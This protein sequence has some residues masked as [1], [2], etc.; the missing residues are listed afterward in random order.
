MSLNSILASAP[1]TSTNY[2]LKAT[3]TTIGNSLIWDNGT[4]VG[5]GNQGTTYKL[6]V[7]G[8]GYFSGILTTGS[9]VGVGVTPS[10]GWVNGYA[11]EVG[12]VGSAVWGRYVNEF[13]LTN[14]YYY[15]A[16]TTSR[17]YAS[18]AP[19]SDYEQYNGIHTWSTAP[20]GT[21]N[22]AVTLT[23]RMTIT[24]AG[25]VGIGT[26]SPVTTNLV[27][28]L[29]IVKSY[30]G[31]TPTS[32]TAQAYYGTQSS[33]YLFGRN[34][35]VS[36]ISN[37]IEEGKIAFGNASTPIYASITT[38]SG[39][40]SVGGDM[41]FKVGSDTERMRITSGGNVGINNTTPSTY[42]DVSNNGTNNN[43]YITTRNT[44]ING[45]RS[46]AIFT[47]S[48]AGGLSWYLVST[49]NGDGD[50]GGGK[51]AI[52]TNNAVGVYLNGSTATTWTGQSD[53]R[54]KDIDSEIENAID[55]VNKL[56]GVRFTWKSDETKKMQVGLI[57]QEVKEVL[58]EAVDFEEG[59]EDYK[60][61]VQYT[62]IIPLLVNAIKE[63][64]AK[65]ETLEAII[66]KK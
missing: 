40:S 37:N 24:N 13:H 22:T 63:L 49:N 3:G 28:A 61:G 53:I 5:I 48:A 54:L 32:T 15:S 39:T 8:T 19:A 4:N 9:N 38:G 21:I 65:V 51:F 56:R 42:L 17:L 16:S 2:I 60:M 10:N 25:N 45:Y 43:A 50:W 36:I 58:P 33:L 29:T 41:Y 47:N 55:K 57:A 11:L 64:S 18:T 12:F 44:G 6:E 14:N 66:N 59:N 34:A 30:N 31:D 46:G 52:S 26:S 35:G 20:S 1:L 27:G 62:D 23:P 7:T